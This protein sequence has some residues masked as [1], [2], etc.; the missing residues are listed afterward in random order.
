MYL[1]SDDLLIIYQLQ[2]RNAPSNTTPKEEKRWFD[3]E[4]LGKAKKQIRGTMGYLKGCGRVHL[5]NGREHTFDVAT[6]FISATDRVIICLPHDTLPTHCRRV[7]CHQSESVGLIHISQAV[8]YLGICQTLI[9]PYEGHDYPQYREQ[10]INKW[11]DKVLDVPEPVL[12]GHY[13][14]G[15]PGQVPDLSRLKY[16][17]ALEENREDWDLPGVVRKFSDRIFES[18]T[19]WEYYRII[20]EIAKLNR[21]DLLA[22]KEGLLLS[23]EKARNNQCT[24][25]YRIVIPRTGCGSCL[26]PSPRIS[27][28]IKYKVLKTL[29]MRISTT[30]NSQNA[31]EFQSLVGTI[32]TLLFIWCH[33]DSPWQYDSSMDQRLKENNPFR[34]IKTTESPRYLFKST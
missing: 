24:R 15:D 30:K 19:P 32:I 28:R 8:D 22:F 11:G 33:V 5:Q 13:L 16:L 25:P 7:K 34:E 17:Q 31:Q 4:V 6:A 20:L 26:C 2:E 12:V 14:Y 3:N 29:P 1:W 10:L 27:S 21:N 9:T 23:I 18:N